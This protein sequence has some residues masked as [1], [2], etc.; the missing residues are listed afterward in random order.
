MELQTERS[1]G[2]SELLGPNNKSI[3]QTLQPM[4][5]SVDKVLRTSWAFNGNGAEERRECHILQKCR[6]LFLTQRGSKVTDVSFA[7]ISL[8]IAKASGFSMFHECP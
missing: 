3:K 2:F 8:K 5:H 4:K 6:V 7:I 1:F